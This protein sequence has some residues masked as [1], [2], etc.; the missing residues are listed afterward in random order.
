[1]HQHH[2]GAQTTQ[3]LLPDRTSRGRKRVACTPSDVCPEDPEIRLRGKKT[4]QIEFP[5]S[6]TMR[7]RK[8]TA[9]PVNFSE[10]ASLYPW[11]HNIFHRYLEIRSVAR[12]ES[13]AVN[14]RGSSNKRVSSS[15]RPPPRIHSEPQACRRH[16]LSQ[17]Q[18]AEF[19]P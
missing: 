14:L 15:Y 11:C 7:N 2:V 9:L 17:G 12:D 16:L 4:T 3:L 19:F 6:Q 5:T 8:K 13:Q 10:P 18:P 1:M